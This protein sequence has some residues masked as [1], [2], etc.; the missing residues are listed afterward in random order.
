MDRYDEILAV[1]DAIQQQ[2]KELQNSILQMKEF[3]AKADADRPAVAD[4]TVVT[5]SAVE[6]D[7]MIQWYNDL[8][9]TASKAEIID[10]LKHRLQEDETLERLDFADYRRYCTDHSYAVFSRSKAGLCFVMPV[11][12]SAGGERVY[13]AFPLPVNAYWYDLGRELIGQ[14][15]SFDHDTTSLSPRL[16]ILRIALLVRRKDSSDNPNGY[17]YVPYQQGFLQFNE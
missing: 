1:L 11:A 14:I 10:K 6:L 4:A 16:N 3:N 13:A 7:D 17:E 5:P 12:L 8:M 15:Y 2:V 9:N